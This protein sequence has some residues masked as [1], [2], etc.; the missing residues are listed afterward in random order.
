MLPAPDLVDRAAAS[1]PA[2]IDPAAPA[3]ASAGTSPLLIRVDS[4]ERQ[5]PVPALLAAFPD[6][7]L[8]FAALPSA[9][10]LLSDD[11]A[12]ERKTAGDFVASILDRR[13]F[14]QTTRMK[15]LF[16]RAML[17]VEG[18]L[19]QVP[20]SIDMEAIRGALAFLTVRAGIT[21]LQLSDA[22]ETAAMLRIMARHAQERLGE[23][24]SLREPRPQIEEL[25][26]AYLVEG[27][28]GIGPRRARQLL[29]HF[30]SPAAIMCA[31]VDELAQVRGIGKKSA[32]R[33]WQAVNAHYRPETCAP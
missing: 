6:V 13:L 7:I 24:V 21:V 30:G 32:Q 5:S 16:S 14:G 12:V 1:Q 25:Y 22:S 18:D 31:A 10:Y 26:A 19:G 28:P 8:S 2:E 4:R 33:I 3:S 23:P 29:A 15:V 17:I 20:H 27:L 11:V 9:D